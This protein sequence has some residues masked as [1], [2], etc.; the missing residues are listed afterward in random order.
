MRYYAGFQTRF[1][2]EITVCAYHGFLGYR[3]FG[4]FYSGISSQSGRFY[5]PWDLIVGYPGN[6][7]WNSSVGLD[8][9]NKS[10]TPSSKPKA[11]VSWSNKEWLDSTYQAC[12]QIHTQR[13]IH[14]I[15][16]N[17]LDLKWCEHHDKNFFGCDL[18]VIVTADVVCWVAP[19]WYELSSV[20]LSLVML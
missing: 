20:M 14:P 6:I 12:T 3:A 9:S 19:P 17:M 5:R 4:N 10:R 13:S 16:R 2:K 18:L 8:V 7:L 11:H 1:L 15:A